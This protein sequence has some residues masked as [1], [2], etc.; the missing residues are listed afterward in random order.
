MFVLLIFMFK[1]VITSLWV[2]EEMTK[3]YSNFI[4]NFK[5]VKLLTTVKLVIYLE[6]MNLLNFDI[7]AVSKLI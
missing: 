3:V 1:F 6:F 4:I 2:I 7:H 5:L